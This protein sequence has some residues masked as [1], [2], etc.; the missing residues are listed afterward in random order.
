MDLHKI[1]P[2]CGATWK[3]DITCQDYFH[4]MLAWEFDNPQ[5]DYNVHHLM[6]LSYYLQHPGLYSPEG[7]KGAV[8]LL[9]DVLES[10]LLPQE[11]RRCYKDR[12]DS[13]KRTWK[14]KGTEALQGFYKNP[15]HWTVTAA[16]VA[17]SGM[18]DYNLNVRRWGRSILET[19]RSSGNLPMP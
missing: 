5:M 1:C 13:R 17:A 14:I 15:P 9:V 19:L 4:Q 12:L 18:Q 8:Q 6:V 11:V 16:D 7:L 2:D 10:G 3:N